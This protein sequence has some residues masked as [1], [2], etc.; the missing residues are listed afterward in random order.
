MSPTIPERL[1]RT[2]SLGGLKSGRRERRGLDRRERELCLDSDAAGDIGGLR[3][4][5]ENMGSAPLGL[6]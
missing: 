2:G 5:G 6:I 4:G 3:W 1:Y